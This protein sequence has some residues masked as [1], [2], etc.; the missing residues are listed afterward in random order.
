M[1]PSQPPPPAQAPASGPW[2]WG[3]VER[4]VR[5]LLGVALVLHQAML[6][7]AFNIYVFTAGLTMVGAGEAVRWDLARRSR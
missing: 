2:T 6:A 1:T 4:A 7:S 3:N 5:L